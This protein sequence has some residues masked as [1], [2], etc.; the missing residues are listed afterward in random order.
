[1]NKKKIL[2]CSKFL[3]VG[4]IEKTLVGLLKGFDYIKYNVTLLLLEKRGP[5]LNDIPKE[6]R[7]LDFKR[8][9]YFDDS[10]KIKKLIF[11]IINAI[12]VK[13]WSVKLK[14]KFD[15]SICYSPYLYECNRLACVASKHNAIWGHSNYYD[16]YD[17]N[18]IKLKKYLYKN[19]YN[20]FENIVFVS[21]K[22]KEDS[23]KLFD[24]LYKKSCVINNIID[25]ENIIDSSKEKINITKEL[26]EPIFI[27]VSRHE[28]KTKKVINII[29]ASIELFE[30]GYKFKLLLVGDGKDTNYYKE[31]VNNSKYKDRIIFTGMQSNPYKYI[32]ASDCLIISSAIEGAPTVAYEAFVLNKYIISTPISDMPNLINEYGGIL[33]KGISVVEI[34]EAILEYLEG[35]LKR[36]EKFD[37]KKYNNTSY[38]KIYNMINEGTK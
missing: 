15:F 17:G 12:K 26:N 22:A 5:F 33:C 18:L 6:V 1:M 30:S 16:L 19:I 24:E 31:I 27:N 9:S 4:G 14:D 13:I 36:K 7:I 3:E 10:S 34:K 8:A 20:K 21:Y 37:F 23:L 2:I 28:E 32:N 11:K 25:G 38:I 35:N 29:K